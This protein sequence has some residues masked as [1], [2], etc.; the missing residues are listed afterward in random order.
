MDLSDLIF[1]ITSEGQNEYLVLDPYDPQKKEIAKDN[2]KLLV[3]SQEPLPYAWENDPERTAKYKE[4]IASK[5]VVIGTAGILADTDRD[6]IIDP[7]ADE[8]AKNE[9]TAARGAYYSVNFDRDGTLKKNDV[10]VADAITWLNTPGVPWDESWNIE[11]EADEQDITPFDISVPDLPKGT[12]AY[13]T[14]GHAEQLHAI[15]VFPRIEAQRTAIWGGYNV[16]G[17]PWTDDDSEPL[18]IEITRWLRPQPTEAGAS[19]TSPGEIKAGTYRMGI[20][21]L[22]FRGMQIPNGTLNGNFGGIIELGVEFQMPGQTERMKKTPIQMK[23]A[24]FLLTHTERPTEKVFVDDLRDGQDNPIGLQAMPIAHPVTLGAPTQW[25]QD[26]VEIGYTQRP[27]G[28]LMQVTFICPYDGLL[29]NW[30]GHEL[31]KT[32]KGIF[33]LGGTLGGGGGDYGGNIE[34]L[35]SSQNHP[36]GRI[37]AGSAMSATLR[38]FLE[39]QEAQTPVVIPIPYTEIE[40]IDE[41][42]SPG[43]DGITYVP[44][45]AEAIELLQEKFDTEEKQIRG[46]LFSRDA[47]QPAVAKVWRDATAASTPYIITDLNYD[48]VIQHWSRFNGPDG[49]YLRLVGGTSGGQI[50][51]VKSVSKAVAEDSNRIEGPDNPAGKLMI[52]VEYFYD[53]GSKAFTNWKAMKPHRAHNWYRKPLQDAHVICVEQTLRW[54]SSTPAIITVKEI[55]EDAEFLTFNQTTLPPLIAATATAAGVSNLVNVPSLFYSSATERDTDSGLSPIA[56]AYTPN[57]ANLQWV[58]SNPVNPKPFGPRNAANADVL[59]SEI[60]AVLPG[61]SVFLDDW[62]LFHIHMGEV[63]CGSAAE[64]QAEANWWTK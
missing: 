21:G 27:G 32:G 34:L 11:N 26:H 6:G 40:H 9:W 57:T 56:I 33:A 19:A 23:V 13:L 55:L 46:V 12:K 25:M 45:P 5:R 58:D 1:D 43:P 64:R 28:P 10:A 37:V 22:V 24:P 15:H 47:V 59:E 44:G 29:A 18:D 8:S 31:L 62:N 42:L 38:T 36:L 60:Q 16:Q 14:L 39:S 54:A 61:Q 51:K 48:D 53:T 52:E 30:P 20:E 7:E 4:Q 2:V 50:A 63:H 3:S 41:V 49:G 35:H 17:R